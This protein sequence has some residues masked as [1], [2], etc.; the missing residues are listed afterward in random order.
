MTV[1]IATGNAVLDAHIKKYLRSSYKVNYVEELESA[2]KKVPDTNVVILSSFLPSAHDDDEAEKNQAFQHAIEVLLEQNIRIV[3]LTDSTIS[4]QTLNDLFEL[5]VYDIILAEDGNV[6]LE[7]I[8]DKVENPTSKE[9][10]EELLNRFSQKGNVRHQP[11]ETEQELYQELHAKKVRKEQMKVQTE[12][13]Q[14]VYHHAEYKKKE[15]PRT[16]IFQSDVKEEENT[17]NHKVSNRLQRR[18]TTEKTKNQTEEPKMFAFWGASTNLGKRTLSQSFANQIVKLGYSV[19]YVEFDYL[20]PALALTTA[21]S[22]PEKNFYQLSLSQDSFDLKQFIANKMDVKITKEMV[23]LFSEI[24]EEFYFLGL[25]AGFNPE[26]FPS[27]TNE[28]FLSTLIA[29]LKEIE[30][31]A[32]VMNL[33]NQ[34]DNLFSF[35]VMLESDVVFAVTTTNPVRINEYRKMKQLLSDTPLN[36]DKWEVIVNQ[37][38]AEITKDVCD[39][40]LRERSILAVPYDIQRPAYELDLRM[41]SPIINEKMNE[42]AGLYGFMPPEPEVTKKKGLFGLKLK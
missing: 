40:L 3:F 29:A 28:G 17:V 4:V 6:D 10:A 37:V 36:M 8:L 33:P 27:I 30:F 11:V 1:L 25:P 19:L 13:E 2:V 15:A 12:F 21:L 41:G 20:N 42:L 9:E 35:P 31:D 22:S 18:K 38:G 32:V 23:S 14:E 26:Q 16:L 39:Q 24:P 7:S 34:I 5:G